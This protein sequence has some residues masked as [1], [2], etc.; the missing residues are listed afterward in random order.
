MKPTDAALELVAVVGG[1]YEGQDGVGVAFV[2]GQITVD[3]WCW[4]G[5]Q[6]AYVR[7]D[8]LYPSARFPTPD[9][10]PADPPSKRAARFHV[11]IHRCVHGMDGDRPPSAAAQTEDALAILDDAELLYCALVPWTRARFGRGR[12]LIGGWTPMGP[13]GDCA[14]GYWTVTLHL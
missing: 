5:C 3:D 8:T 1:A 4:S 6:T 7:L 11:G 13:L 2:P 14:G 10:T 9:T 12:S